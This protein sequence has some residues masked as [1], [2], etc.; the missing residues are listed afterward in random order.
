[1]SS[2][3][4]SLAAATLAGA[5]LF[6]LSPARGQSGA[7]ASVTPPLHTDGA[8]IR[9]ARG[10]TIRLVSVNWYG[11]D[12]GEYVAGGL[13]RVQLA[14]LAHTIRALGFNSV[15]LPWAN[16]IVEDN[17]RVPAYALKANP[18]LKGKHALEIMDDVV[19]ALAREQLMVILDN[20]VSRSDWCC[21]EKDGNGLWYNRE[22]P[23]SRWLE[24]W[25]TLVRRYQAQPFVVAADLRNELRSGA[26][27]GG[28]DPA[29]D[30]R[31][32]AERGGNAVLAVNPSLLIVVEST[33]YSL[34]FNGVRSLPVRLSVP[35]RLVY[36]PHNYGWSQPVPKSYPE[37]KAHLDQQWGHLLQGANAAPVWIGELG[38]CQKLSDCRQYGEWFPFLVRYIAE[39]GVGWSYWAL[40]GTESSGATRLYGTPEGYGLLATG[41]QSVA[42]PEA[43]KQLEAVGL[44]PLP[45]APPAPLQLTTDH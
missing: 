3:T 41:Y 11:F 45:P 37:F 24:D 29:L 23:E 16:Q 6:G 17:P 39:T 26:Q 10:A 20:H 12:Q 14:E 9:D 35:N 34:N 28:S 22:Y 7:P 33:E 36:S 4:L 21:N 43:L 18:Q 5:L 27:W 25:Q 38:V 31:A 42:A 2:R 19:A 44:D 13:D 30:W 32:A 15:R 8:Q 40:N 1:M